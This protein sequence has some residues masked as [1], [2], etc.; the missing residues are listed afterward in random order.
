MAQSLIETFMHL[1]GADIGE[2]YIFHYQ[3]DILIIRADL[4][5]VKQASVLVPTEVS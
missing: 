1:H 4:E 5:R 2:V 3:D